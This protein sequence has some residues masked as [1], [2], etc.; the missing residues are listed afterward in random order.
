MEEQALA[1]RRP[2]PPIAPAE[3]AEPQ[4]LPDQ[5]GV[6]ARAPR[7]F[8]PPDRDRRGMSL[9]A[10]AAAAAIVVL[11]LGLAVLDMRAPAWP[12]TSFAAPTTTGAGQTSGNASAGPPG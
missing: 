1:R 10:L 7:R 6:P 3:S 9:L 8:G 2:R 5:L 4:R 11:V 12:P